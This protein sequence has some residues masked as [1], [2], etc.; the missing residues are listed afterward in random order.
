LHRESIYQPLSVITPPSKTAP[1]SALPQLGPELTLPHT[2]KMKQLQEQT[3]TL[4]YAINK[5]RDYLQ[6]ELHY[7]AMGPDH[8]HLLPDEHD[9]RWTGRLLVLKDAQNK[10]PPRDPRHEVEFSIGDQY[11]T[12]LFV[13]TLNQI[14][15]QQAGTQLIADSATGYQAQ[16][17][18]FMPPGQGQPPPPALKLPYMVNNA[19]GAPMMKRADQPMMPGP[20]PGPGMPKL[21]Q[22]MT[23]APGGLAQNP[24]L[25]Q[26]RAGT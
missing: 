1:T 7:S 17:L 21:P 8:V 12:Q 26:R 10:V 24:M 3:R 15:L 14:E 2:N 19:N 22:Q 5:S 4:K 11:Q 6:L 25:M 20:A 23:V 9:P 13:N 18:P 16:P